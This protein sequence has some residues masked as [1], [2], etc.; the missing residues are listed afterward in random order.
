[1]IGE[2]S[3]GDVDD[4]R[5]LPESS[6][7]TDLAVD[8]AYPLTP[9]QESVYFDAL[10][11]DTPELHV[12]QH[13]V[14]IDGPIDVDL[15][16]TS[17]QSVVDRHPGLRTVF[18]RR[19]IAEP[20]QVVCSHVS[21]NIDV[22]DL[23]GDPDPDATIERLWVAD[24]HRGFDLTVPPLM[25][26]TL[27]RRAA[28]H[29]ELMTTQPHM[30]LDGWSNS[31]VFDE[32]FTAYGALRAGTS[33][34]VEPAPPMRDFV[35][36]L[37]ARDATK[38]K[39]F[40]VEHLADLDSPT[41]LTDWKDGEVL[42]PDTSTRCEEEIE[43]EL[44]SRL[45]AT[46]RRLRVSLGAVLAGA[47]GILIGRHLDR[48]DVVFS[49]ILAGRP[50]ELEGVESI[51]GTLINTVPLRLR[52]DDG[53]AAGEWLRGV[54]RRQTSLIGHVST[55][56]SEVQSWTGLESG[57]GLADT[58][59]SFGAFSAE[60]ASAGEVQYRSVAGF[61][62]PAFPLSVVVEQ[63]E[64][65]TVSVQ[66]YSTALSPTRSR[67]LLTH[68]VALLGA[69]ADDPE[70]P[71]G[72]LQ[73]MSPT[74][75]SA[76][77]TDRRA[78]AV[79]AIPDV[80]VHEL[81]AR[82]A[83]RT[84][85][86]I[87]IIH[88]DDRVTIREVDAR[89]NRLANHLMAKGVG[90]G[91]VVAVCLPRG[92]DFPVSLLAIH[93]A[94]AAF[95]PLDPV[96]P[97]ERIGYMLE[98][99]G[100]GAVITTSH[101]ARTTFRGSES[102]IVALDEAA[103][104]VSARPS[105]APGVVVDE[106]QLA[107]V[108]FTSGSTGRPKGVATQHRAFNHFVHVFDVPGFSSSDRVLAVTAPTFD[109][110]LM[111]YFITLV[112]GGTVVI[113]TD[114]M[115]A[116]P[117]RLGEALDSSAISTMFATPTRWQLLIAS[118]WAGR[119][120]LIACSGGE[121]LS[122]V[123]IERLRDR[124]AE[125]WNLYGPTE[126]TVWSS[127]RQVLE[128]LHGR[129]LGR[130]FAN[131]WYYV[132]DSQLRP[133]PA[134][135]PGMLYIG[136]GGL[137]REYLDAT[138]LTAASFFPDP[139]D[140]GS[141]MY[142]TGDMVLEEKGEIHF[143]GRRDG[144][145]KI[146][147]H[148]VE[149]GEVEGALSTHPGVDVVAAR[150]I[151]SAP[152]EQRLV[153]WFVTSAEPAPSQAELRSYLSERL[154]DYMVPVVVQRIRDVPLTNSGKLDR[155]RLPEVDF[156]GESPL[157]PASPSS[158][159]ERLIAETCAALLGVGSVDLRSRFIDL[160]GH[161][162]LSLRLVTTIEERTGVEIDPRDLLV[163][164]LRGISAVIEAGRHGAPAPGTALSRPWD[165]E[166]YFFRPGDRQLFGVY[167]APQQKGAERAVVLCPPI[168][169]EYTHTHAALRSLAERLARAGLGVLRFDWTGT[170]D[171][172]GEG[173]DMSLDQWA[174]D[175]TDAANEVVA[176]SGFEDVTLVGLRFGATIAATASTA[177]S[178]CRLVL[179]DPVVVGADY[180]RM[181]QRHHD[182][183]L[184]GEPG[185][186][187][188]LLGQ[189]FPHRLRTEIQGVDLGKRST[190]PVGSVVVVSGPGEEVSSRGLGDTLPVHR[191]D[192]AG[193]WD[194]AST[195]EAIVVPSRIPAWIAGLLQEGA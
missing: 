28:E 65:L 138:E 165:P 181:Q 72:A 31:L 8:D 172:W 126:T 70:T 164:S 83:A 146:R 182:H 4:R 82:Q 137:A 178:R 131:V 19:G 173:E 40:W 59:L 16:R 116:D 55:S 61:G 14:R 101:L 48:S 108:F 79:C 162:L 106:D 49:V 24:R 156:G 193:Q 114:A 133:V 107:Y 121:A 118:G 73:M 30:L 179:W 17:W 90:Q 41:R 84:P 155:A 97:A 35:D 149:L 150:L 115:L 160:G 157:G 32:V 161:S 190:W 63:L 152:G 183:L 88:G 2:A 85:D 93:R 68:L 75:R 177:K 51:V 13:R 144:Q 77:T 103:E 44:T 124:T 141:R 175:V 64:P 91:S 62:R 9:F 170:G 180:L 36:W 185:H 54:H 34:S 163:R 6:P 71:V 67:Q 120:G 125:L 80:P 99:A 33:P 92:P 104:D 89:A 139:F 10:G 102:M 195:R 127:A 25:R 112:R 176:R 20:Q 191:V 69:I 37:Q 26:V 94:G 58:L 123:L 188:E 154:P 110:V 168:G 174:D 171:S 29:H 119:K 151:A 158:D 5:R 38:E 45:V 109:P 53:Q 22:V 122:P 135:R 15:L 128:P 142:R 7:G 136:G 18:V 11:S 129:A 169:W 52:I 39:A 81:V 21:L 143:L 194:E 95:V 42:T 134:G 43:P 60:G 56:L 148:R 86:S 187:V 166:P 184:G 105:S 153:A 96:L 74:E 3:G 87:A 132:L 50:A 167:H 66:S 98:T 47:V 147:G 140:S 100:A 23:V 111:E 189:P 145:V 46:A 76:L 1:M 113:A 12:V 57:V 27:F 192:D 117:R 186:S 130:A 78:R 159:A